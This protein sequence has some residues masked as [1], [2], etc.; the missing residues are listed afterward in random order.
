[1]RR[2]GVVAVLAAVSGLVSSGPGDAAT[3]VPSCVP[4]GPPVVM[5]GEVEPEDAKTYLLLPFRVPNGVTRVEVGYSWADRPGPPSTP[6]T[7]TVFD[8]GLWD[9]H[10]EGTP[11][12][13]R[14]W[15]GSRQGKLHEGQPPVWVEAG[16]AERGYVPGPIRSGLW[17]V[18][19]GVAAVGPNGATWRVEVSC[20]T[21]ASKERATRRRVDPT[22]VARREPGWYHGDFHLHAFHSNQA[23]PSWPAFVA[24]AREAGLDFLPVTE[25]VT[26]AHWDELGPVQE[27]NPDL[28][29]WPGREIITYF[30]HANALGE[31]P[32]VIDWRHGHDGVSLAE[33]QRR[34]KAD[35]ALFQVNHPT[36]F[37][38]PAF[39]NFCRGC[40]FELGDEIDWDLVDTIEVLTGPVVAN[41]S[42]AG[43]PST[44]PLGAQN[45][46][47]ADAV[48]L[49]ERLL[50]EGHRITAVSGSDSKGVEPN[51]AE[52][53]R[54]GYGS[55]ATA[56]F[57]RELSRPA[58]IE[59]IGA[60]HAYVRT[61]GVHRSPELEME[62]VAPGGARGTFGD[63]L[64]ADAANVA[65]RVRGGAGQLLRVVRN[66]QPIAVVPVVGD[67]FTHRFQAFRT[68][69]EGPLGTFWRVETL[70]ETSLTT[71]GNPIF[72][73]GT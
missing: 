43:G 56:V 19:L 60:G 64:P 16:S 61:R 18:D 63:T 4:G 68:P 32:S 25:Y 53:E 12:G 7:Q 44:D 1:M 35:G 49:W 50:M 3:S 48:D 23:G 27:A 8:L 46:F 2:L 67:D 58:L 36:I 57:A 62:A 20:R 9:D 40:Y 21:G 13:F 31:T 14:G 17:K 29:I 54:R 65:V 47:V 15:S 39:T 28:V 73:A 26:R 5:T 33:I 11:K 69:D 42:D 72:L 41:P 6:L 38:P 37:P 45:P 66:G 59:A 10:G 51:D 22:H 52:R 30:G 71:I 34:T 55:S 70:D 24:A